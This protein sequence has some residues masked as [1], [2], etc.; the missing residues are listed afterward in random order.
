MNYS[1]ARG[2]VNIQTVCSTDSDFSLASEDM[3]DLFEK[4]GYR[5]SVVQ[6]GHHRA[7][8]IDQQS[9]LQT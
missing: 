4:R 3:C 5:D 6:V 1:A 2:T 9:A 7:Q 8:R